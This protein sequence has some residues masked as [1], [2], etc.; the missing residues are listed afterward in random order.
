VTHLVFLRSLRRLLVRGSVVPSSPILVTLMMEEPHVVTS[1]KTPFFSTVLFP[2]V[3]H[4]APCNFDA[5]DCKKGLLRLKVMQYWRGWRATR[6]LA[7]IIQEKVEG[8]EVVEAWVSTHHDTRTGAMYWHGMANATDNLLCAPLRLKCCYKEYVVLWSDMIKK[9][10][11][12]QLE[13]WLP[14][15]SWW[16]LKIRNK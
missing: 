1:Q 13:I 16:S 3:Y 15:L 9:K 12:A 7:E 5:K 10:K 14:Q 6:E 11:G 4:F 8:V 2:T